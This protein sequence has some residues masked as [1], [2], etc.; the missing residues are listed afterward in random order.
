MRQIYRSVALVALVLA[1][2]LAGCEDPRKKAEATRRL[3]LRL[4]ECDFAEPSAAYGIVGRWFEGGRIYE[5]R[6]DGRWDSRSGSYGIVEEGTW[7]GDQYSIE[8]RNSFG[9]GRG[10]LSNGRL[11]GR[12]EGLSY[13]SDFVMTRCK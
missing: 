6:G 2:L 3:N 9:I 13:A 4:A 7:T 5:F 10:R 12:H 1:A 11:V 8:Y